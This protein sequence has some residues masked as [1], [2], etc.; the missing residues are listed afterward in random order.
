MSPAELTA[1]GRNAVDAIPVLQQLY[2]ELRLYHEDVD[3]RALP[4]GRWCWL[5]APGRVWLVLPPRRFLWH[6][7]PVCLLAHYIAHRQE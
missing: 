1:P 5:H 7:S 6:P 4:P 2:P 3:L